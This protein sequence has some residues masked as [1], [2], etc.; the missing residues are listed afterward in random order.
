M[1]L[2]VDAKGD[3]EIGSMKA[4]GVTVADAVGIATTAGSF[5]EAALN[6]EFGGLEEPCDKPLPTHI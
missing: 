1:A 2:A 4:R 3:V 5:R 6:H